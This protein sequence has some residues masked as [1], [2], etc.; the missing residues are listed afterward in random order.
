M[1]TGDKAN[2]K[3]LDQEW[4]NLQVKKLNIISV[5]CISLLIARDLY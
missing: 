5:S 2:L 1:K 3:A 4:D